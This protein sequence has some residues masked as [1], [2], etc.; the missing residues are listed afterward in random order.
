MIREHHN[1][2]LFFVSVMLQDQILTVTGLGGLNESIPKEKI[3]IKIFFQIIL[4]WS[5]KKLRKMMIPIVLSR[6]FHFEYFRNGRE[7]GQNW[8]FLKI[9]WFL[10]HLKALNGKIS[11]WAYFLKLAKMFWRYLN[12]SAPKK[13]FFLGES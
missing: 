10:Y 12:F 9:I 11:E 6:L 13:I 5:S 4:N 1:E 7:V 2:K 8:N 3:V